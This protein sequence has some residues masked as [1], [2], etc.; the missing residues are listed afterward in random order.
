MP[1][2]TNQPTK[3]TQTIQSTRT[4]EL[5]LYNRRNHCNA[6]SDGVRLA[7]TGVTMQKAKSPNLVVEDFRAS[8]AEKWQKINAK[9][10]GTLYGKTFIPFGNEGDMGD[11]IMTNVIQQ[12]NKLLSETKQRIVHNLSNVDEIIEI[13][14]GEDIDMDPAGIT[15]RDIFYNHQDK[16]GT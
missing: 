10:G 6:V 3:I 8:M 2:P 5:L 13:A 9:N 15:L 11:A 16:E 14:L 7:T 1:H 4:R 12:Q